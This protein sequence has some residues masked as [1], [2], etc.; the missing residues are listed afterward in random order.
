MGLDPPRWPHGPTDPLSPPHLRRGPVHTEPQPGAPRPGLQSATPF[1]GRRSVPHTGSVPKKK[2]GVMFK[3]RKGEVKESELLGAD[4]A[5][6]EQVGG[7]TGPGIHHQCFPAWR[8]LRGYGDQTN[9]RVTVNKP[10]FCLLA[11][12]G[13]R[14]PRSQR[15]ILGL[16]TRRG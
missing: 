15:H 2:S 8:K 5:S 11:V 9:W 12:V 10:S 4:P 7:P 13:T 1:R 3:S 14:Q 6:S 16:R